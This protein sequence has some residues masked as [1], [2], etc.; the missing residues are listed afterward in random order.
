MCGVRGVA[1]VM[2]ASRQREACPKVETWRRCL[3]GAD[4]VDDAFGVASRA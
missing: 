4:D 3:G 1:L 2:Q